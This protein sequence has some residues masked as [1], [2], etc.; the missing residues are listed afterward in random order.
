[1]RDVETE[2][3]PLKVIID[4]RL[5]LPPDA[6]LLSD[7]K[8]LVVYAQD[9]EGKSAL[10]R[11]RGAELLHLPDTN[12]QIDL[13]ALMSELGRRGINEVHVE[14]GSRLNGALLSA[15]LVDEFLIYLAPCLIGHA[16]RGLFDMPALESLV[17][18]PQLAIRDL[19][20][21]GSDIRIL[22]RPML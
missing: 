21:I 4:S 19:R 1:M 9:D 10:L 20:L 11:E 2:R 17:G 22:A 15:G 3:Q 5:E 16:A 18:K 14:A 13:H 8:V 7:A 6:R 12:G